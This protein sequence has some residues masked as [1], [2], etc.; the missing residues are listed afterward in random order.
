MNFVLY[1]VPFEA[2]S[3]QHFVKNPMMK[4]VCLLIGFSVLASCQTSS[5][6]PG[7]AGTTAVLPT[8]SSSYTFTITQS[9]DSIFPAMTHVIDTVVRRWAMPDSLATVYSL[10]YDNHGSIQ[11]TDS[12]A[13]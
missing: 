3:E 4:R 9:G 12:L 2:D 6:E 8:L 13:Y 11:T 7:T 10:V 1:C 5:T